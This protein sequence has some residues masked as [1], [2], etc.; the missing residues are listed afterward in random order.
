MAELAC[1]LRLP[2]RTVEGLVGVSQVLVHD[3]PGALAASRVGEI[4]YR[5]AQILVEHAATLSPEAAARLEAAV[6]PLATSATPTQFDRRTR[7]ARERI[8]PESITARHRRAE[9]DRTV[10]CTSARDG[11]AWVS[12]YLPASDAVGICTRVTEAAIS[13]QGP[14]ETRTLTQL[15]ADVFRDLLLD[16]DDDDDDEG[17]AIVGTATPDG[18]A[19]PHRHA[20]RDLGQTARRPR[21]KFRGI[22]PRVLVTV[23]VLTLLGHSDEPGSLE[24]YGPIDP[25]TARELAANAPSFTRLLTHPET[26][27]VLSVGRSR[28]HVPEDLRIWLRVRDGTGVLLWTSPT[29]HAYTLT[30]RRAWTHGQTHG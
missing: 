9:G 10:Q 29:G 12:A 27:A 15:R 3:L 24:G 28:Y 2:E 16:D 7:V 25:D 17:H 22:K 26:G 18:Q 1:A 14:G 23:P 13:I 8:H 4:S 19:S 11:M 6:L 5:H 30:P 20:T 21:R